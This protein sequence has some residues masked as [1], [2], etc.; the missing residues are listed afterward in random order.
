MIALDSIIRCVVC[1]NFDGVSALPVYY[2]IDVSW[3]KFRK[4]VKC[5]QHNAA[6]YR[7][8]TKTKVLLG[9]II[10]TKAAAVINLCLI[11]SSFWWTG[12]TPPYHFYFLLWAHACIMYGN[13]TH[14]HSHTHMHPDTIHTH[15]LTRTGDVSWVCILNYVSVRPCVLCCNHRKLLYV[16]NST[17]WRTNK[18]L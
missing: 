11:T 18:W 9:C 12:F 1:K 5:L 6:P 15:T 4:V 7:R 16:E 13:T 3:L 17:N 10:L 14:T 8:R 2:I